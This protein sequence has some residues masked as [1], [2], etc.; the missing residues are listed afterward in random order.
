MYETRQ[1]LSLL[2]SLR[3]G[4]RGAPGVS[5]ALSADSLRPGLRV[6]ELARTN[7][8][9]NKPSVTWALPVSEAFGS[10][11][12]AEAGLSGSGLRGVCDCA[13]WGVSGKPG[14]GA[15]RKTSAAAR[16][17]VSARS[18]PRS[19]LAWAA[20]AVG[21]GWGAGRGWREV[22]TRTCCWVAQIISVFWLLRGIWPL[23]FAFSFIYF[24]LFSIL[25]VNT[26]ILSHPERFL[27]SLKIPSSSPSTAR[28]QFPAPASPR[29]LCCTY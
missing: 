8:L 2:C 7:A 3:W 1:E 18:S 19:S 12:L 26:N 24:C 15:P 10:W 21:G 13:S 22:R 16:T 11:Q 5:D 23:G 17:T 6:R 28:R 4:A 20:A 9:T 14:R 25:F 27:P 29:A